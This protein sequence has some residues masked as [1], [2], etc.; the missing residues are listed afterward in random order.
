MVN[1]L[2]KLISWTYGSTQVHHG[3]GCDERVAKVW[4]IQ[5]TFIL[6]VLTNTV[7]G[8]THHLI[9]SVAESWR[10]HLT[11]QMLVSRFRP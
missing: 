10:T 1:S 3:M 4:N 8:S 7:V 11:K 5:L 9:T 2:K 6:K